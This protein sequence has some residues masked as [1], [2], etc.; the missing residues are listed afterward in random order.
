V[1][2][3]YDQPSFFNDDNPV[4]RKEHKCTECG[5]IIKPGERYKK[6]SGKWDGVF[7][8]HR[9]CFDCL[10]VRDV[11][12][13]DGFFYDQIWDD[14]EQH[15]RDMNGQIPESCILDLT[16]AARERIFEIIEQL[17]MDEDD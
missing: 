1:D 7:E 5:R 9:T 11:F 12:F 14:L 8:T 17:W 10:S 15:I 2:T 13:C 4:A 3:S 16:P 6:E